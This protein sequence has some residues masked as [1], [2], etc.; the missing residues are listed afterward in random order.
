MYSGVGPGFGLRRHNC[1]SS[2]NLRAIHGVFSRCFSRP[3]LRLGFADGDRLRKTSPREDAL[4]QQFYMYAMSHPN[5]TF[6]MLDQFLRETLGKDGHLSSFRIKRPF[7]INGGNPNGVP[8]KIDGGAYPDFDMSEEFPGDV[9]PASTRIDRVMRPGGDIESGYAVVWEFDSCYGPTIVPVTE[10]PRVLDGQPA[11]IKLEESVPQQSAARV[12]PNT[13]AV[14]QRQRAR[15]GPS[16]DKVFPQLAHHCINDGGFTLGKG[17]DPYSAALCC[18]EG[19]TVGDIDLPFNGTLTELLWA[20]EDA[21]QRTYSLRD[22]DIGPEDRAT[23]AERAQY[24][25]AAR[26]P[27]ITKHVSLGKMKRFIQIGTGWSGPFAKASKGDA[28][29]NK[30]QALWQSRPGSA[31]F[32]HSVEAALDAMEAALR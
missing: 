1:G 23:D 7:M 9:L 21:C 31:A 22:L 6:K 27:K 29:T 4:R 8:D 18:N 12:Q 26:Y 16:F 20:L 13:A 32:G 2:G 25:F 17:A 11:S 3:S 15:I 19:G 24:D 14:A 28:F 30:D 5:A 10:R